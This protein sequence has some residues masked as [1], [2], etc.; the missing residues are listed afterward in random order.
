VSDFKAEMHKIRFPLGLRPRPHWGSL[1]CSPDPLTVFKGLLQRG[2]EGK[3]GRRRGRGGEGERNGRRSE[4]KEE[5]G[6]GRGHPQIF[7]R[8]TAR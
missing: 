7:W 3:R 2:G 5:E 1:Q 6:K 4:E 8:R